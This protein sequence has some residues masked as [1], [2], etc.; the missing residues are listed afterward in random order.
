MPK[1]VAERNVEPWKRRLYLPAYSISAA[2][3]YV[4][5]SSQTISYWF[6]GG[7]SLGPALPGKE[8]HK[9]LS[10]L[11]LIEIAFVATFRGLNVS[12]QRIRKARE[13]AAQTLNSEYPFIELR[14]KTEGHHM[15]LDLVDIDQ[16]AE[17]NRLIVADHY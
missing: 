9:P 3:Q 5:T 1:M 17:L 13:Y 15:L 2:A 8:Q 6:Y 7:G 4:G 12:L 16:D 11:Q 14:W 10:Y